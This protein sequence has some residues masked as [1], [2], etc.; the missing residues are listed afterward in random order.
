[1]L[2]KKTEDFIV[3]TLKHQNVHVCESSVFTDGNASRKYVVVQEAFLMHM[4]MH[5]SCC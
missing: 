4:H 3:C 5:S 2:L 1:M